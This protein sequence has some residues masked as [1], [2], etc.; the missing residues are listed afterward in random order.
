MLQAMEPLTPSLTIA[1]LLAQWPET[2]PVLVSRR[3][4][5]VGCEMNGFETILDAAAVY[6]V[7]HHELIGDLRRVID[8]HAER[9]G[10]T[11]N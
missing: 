4:A 6:G 1:T 2:A 11:C 3:M 5:C 7:S 9:A 8:A 10:C